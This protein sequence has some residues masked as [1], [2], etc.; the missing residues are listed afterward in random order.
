MRLLR[1][2]RARFFGSAMATEIGAGFRKL[3]AR[4]S[5]SDTMKMRLLYHFI[6]KDC[7][8][9]G[10]AGAVRQSKLD[11]WVLFQHPRVKHLTWKQRAP[12]MS[13]EQICRAMEYLYNKQQGCTHYRARVIYDAPDTHQKTIDL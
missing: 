5:S 11:S 4:L 1:A 8:R 6:L 12:H 7:N 13:D 10:P 9:Y 2:M 3:L